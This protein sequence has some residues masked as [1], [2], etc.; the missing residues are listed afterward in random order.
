MGDVF[1]SRDGTGWEHL[2]FAREVDLVYEPS[3]LRRC[4]FDQRGTAVYA[5]VE[6]TSL[7]PPTELVLTMSGTVV[8]HIRTISYRHP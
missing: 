4:E 2:G 8:P 7:W 6:P 3:D 1:I 5:G